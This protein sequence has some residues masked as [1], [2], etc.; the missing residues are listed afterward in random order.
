MGVIVHAGRTLQSGHYYSYIRER[1]PSK[2]WYC[3]NDSSITPFDVSKLEEETFGSADTDSWKCS[4][5]YVLFYDKVPA[6]K[7]AGKLNP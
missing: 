4:T 5:A 7:K 2:K 1:P 3:F 6:K